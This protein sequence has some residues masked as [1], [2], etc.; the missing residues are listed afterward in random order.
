MSITWT[1]IAT[2]GYF[3]RSSGV[4]GGTG[5]GGGGGGPI[6][7]PPVDSSGGIEIIGSNQEFWGNK[8]EYH[9]TGTTFSSL[10][11]FNFA[12]LG[13]LYAEP[14]NFFWTNLS[15]RLRIKVDFSAP[16]VTGVW[17][18]APV[19]CVNPPT[20]N[21][22]GF[23][24]YHMPIMYGATEAISYSG[25]IYACLFAGL[26]FKNPQPY[27]GCH[28]GGVS[29]DSTTSY[30][31][32]SEGCNISSLIA[33]EVITYSTGFNVNLLLRSERPVFRGVG[34]GVYRGVL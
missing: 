1:G 10:T 16:L 17:V 6:E 7:G 9:T 8:L 31:N 30:T 13:Y 19:T 2:T 26:S 14:Q 33:G 25:G 22:F 23:Y 24:S 34:V 28:S 5:S 15:A 11:G 29:N 12:D 4:G 32:I 20:T 27:T 18:E 3:I 21:G